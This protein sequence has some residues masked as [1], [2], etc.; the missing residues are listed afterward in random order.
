MNI[1]L[2][3]SEF[4]PTPGGIARY[5][6]NA[7]EMFARGGHRVTVL[8][9][10][11]ADEESTLP[12]GARLVRFAPRAARLADGPPASLGDAHAA[13]PYNVL[14][15]ELALSYE[16]AQRAA[17]LAQRDGVLP[18]VIESQEYG[19]L[20]YYLIQRRLVDERH[21]L[22][23]VPV[24]VHLHSPEFVLAPVDQRPRHRLPGYW[25][26]QME[27]FCILAADALLSPSQ[28]L[29]DG[30]VR[31]V[32][33]VAGR[34]RVLPYPYT[35]L[36][37]VER[38]PTPG[39]L[40]YFGRLEARKGVLE[41]VQ[42][43]ARLWERGRQFRLTL[44]GGDTLFTPRAESMGQFLRRRYGRWVDAGLLAIPG[45]P[46]APPAL[47]ERLARAWAVVIP[48]VWENFP[49]TC[50]EAMSLG[51]PV[52]ASTSGGQAELI[53]GDGR[54]GALFDWARPGDCEAAIE[55]VLAMGAAELAA[56]GEAARARAR[57]VTAIEAVLP[58]REAHLVQIIEQ[59]AGGPR[60]FPCVTPGIEGNA[61]PPDAASQPGLL[62]VVVPFYNL[63]AY[64]EETIASVAA[65][66]YRPLEVVVV[67]D[68][69]DDAASVAALERAR[70]RHPDL[71]RV[72]RTTNQ[73]LALARNTGAEQAHGEFV[74]FVDADDLV[75]PDFFARAVGALRRYA[76]AS[77]TYSWVRFFGDNQGCWPTWNTE[78]P[79]L[80]AHNMLTPLAVVRRADFLAFGRNSPELPYALED[81][82][83]WIGMVETGCVGISL[84]DMLVGYRVRAD[85]MLR[86]MNES[87]A[88][89]LSDV[90]ARRHPALYRRFGE[91]LFGLLNA[92]GRAFQWLHPAMYYESQPA[93]SL[94]RYVQ[95]VSGRL[96][97]MRRRHGLWWTARRVATRA[98]GRARRRQRGR[99]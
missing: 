13:F 21:P 70:S 83:G 49:N 40:V 93:P 99:E 74:A 53:G 79:Y 2:L 19:A 86:Q 76:N 50:I 9:P 90:I 95:H 12:D 82:D 63:G 45:V 43:C 16:L 23:S 4:P 80:L 66:T 3:T 85:S 73:G 75:E 61:Q 97:D 6:A 22:A 5:V 46:L 71:V 69:S 57:A 30:V 8:A 72:H 81:Y 24:L 47:W 91:E 7:A 77:F 20:P 29:A 62:S 25:V 59:G 65:A 56:M 58:Q 67:D 15:H 84:P 11:A 36:P 51:L 98:F 31:E 27:K 32:P 44:I 41:L 18:D 94:R 88:L 64:V 39:D 1:W 37:P 38:R 42:C 87:Q 52:I 28:Y 60:P 26:G 48:S 78:L 68:G 92:N 55:R 10:G 35:P 89:Y 54:C 33:Q 17:D 14:S 34:I 96:A